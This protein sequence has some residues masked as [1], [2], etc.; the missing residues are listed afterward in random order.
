MHAFMYTQSDTNANIYS[1]M[2]KCNCYIEN[3]SVQRCNWKNNDLTMRSKHCMEISSLA[4]KRNPPSRWH[5]QPCFFKFMNCTHHIFLDIYAIRTKNILRRYTRYEQYIE[6][7]VLIKNVYLIGGLWYM[8]SHLLHLPL[9]ASYFHFQISL[10][11]HQECPVQ[12]MTD[13]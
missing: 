7:Q 12:V 5:L 9:M 11:S 4:L 8:R 1:Q 2:Q 10:Q 3:K 6:Y 13:L